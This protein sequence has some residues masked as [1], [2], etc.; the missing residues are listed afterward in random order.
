MPSIWRVFSAAVCAAVVPSGARLMPSGPQPSWRDSSRPSQWVREPWLEMLM[1]LPLRSSALLIGLSLPTARSTDHGASAMAATAI[2]G[3]PLATKA[4][5]G[6]EPMPM[7]M[8]PA[9]IAC[10][11]RGPP[12]KLMISTSMPCFLNRPASVPTCSGTNWKVPACGWPTRTLVCASAPCAPMTA[13]SANT[14]DLRRLGIGLFH[15]LHQGANIRTAFTS[16][17]NGDGAEITNAT[18]IMA[19]ALLGRGRGGG[20][21]SAFVTGASYG[22]GAA[23]AQKLARDGYDVAISATRT[24]NLSTVRLALADAGMRIVPVALDLRSEASIA[25]AFG[26]VLAAFGTLDLLVNNAGA[27]LRKR[28]VDV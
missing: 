23:T 20:M 17:G 16:L 15:V 26:E 3:A 28:A 6:P 24:D 11:T 8:A 18:G 10:C 19:A 1:V 5:S 22:V 9:A 12:P 4:S 2:S 13:R 25:Q 21:P 7:S 14:K 27:N